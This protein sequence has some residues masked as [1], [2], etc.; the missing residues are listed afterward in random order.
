MHA[1]RFLLAYDSRA[2]V[3]RAVR[4]KRKKGR[5]LVKKTMRFFVACIKA[6]V[7]IIIC[8][9]CARGLNRDRGRYMAA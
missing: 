9:R 3:M 1:V 4:N 2:L 6:W 7:C 8:A 5:F